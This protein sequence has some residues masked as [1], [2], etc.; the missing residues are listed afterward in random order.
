M[1]VHPDA[2]A[3]RFIFTLGFDAMAEVALVIWHVG[4]YIRTG[5]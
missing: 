5:H 4:D 1:H 3:R 2:T